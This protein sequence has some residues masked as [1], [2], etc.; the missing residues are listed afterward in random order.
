MA[1]TILRSD[2]TDQ[3]IAD[4]GR[5][6]EIG[7]KEVDDLTQ[8]FEGDEF[9]EGRKDAAYR[10]LVPQKIS[11]SEVDGFELKENVAPANRVLKYAT[12]RKTI[13]PYGTRYEYTKED[14][15]DNPDSV[16]A[17]CTEELDDWAI[18]MKKYAAANALSGTHS[19]IKFDTTLMKTS[20]KALAVLNSV[21]EAERFTDKGYLWIMPGM[22]EIVLKNELLA[23]NGGHTLTP[24]ALDK[25]YKGYVGSY[26]GFNIMTPK[27]ANKFLQDDT[28]YY[29]YFIGKDEKGRNPLRILK[30]KGTWTEVKHSPLGSGILKN[31][32][33]EIVPDYNGQ[34]GGIGCNIAGFAC[35]I[36]DDRFVLKCTIAKTD[37]SAPTVDTTIV[38]D[39]DTVITNHGGTTSVSPK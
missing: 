24:E 11:P 8:F 32:A 26:N 7:A 23:A 14:Y 12:Y 9:P 6:I 18:S 35:Y 1:N 28:N 37:I 25:A 39:I 15:E 31:A 3:Q 38:D 21:L 20:D 10:V 19:S 16:V 5:R 30:K 4:V 34:V 13:K 33:G 2:L 29:M 36:R 27:G 22:L 17:D